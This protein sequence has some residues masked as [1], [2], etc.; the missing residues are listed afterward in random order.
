LAE[1]NPLDH[2]L[3]YAEPRRLTPFSAWHEHIPFAMLLVDLARP[4][5]LVEL[6]THAGDS[7]CAFCQAVSELKL[8][9]KCFAVDTWAGDEHSAAY[10][11]EILADL[12]KHHDPLYGRFSELVQSTFDEAL[13]RFD[14][15]SV[16]VLHI[17]GFHTYEAVRHDFE[18]WL[19]KMSSRGIVLFHDTAVTGFGFGVK[20][21]WDEVRL[22]YAG[23]E[24]LHGN[25]LGVLGVGENLPDAVRGLFDSNE[26]EVEKLR[27]LFAALGRRLSLQI[28]VERL[29]GK[30]AEIKRSIG[31][32]A[33]RR[34]ERFKIRLLPEEEKY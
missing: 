33:L 14:D 17:D 12:R 28:E 18:S 10:G 6:G 25:G 8:D 24:F 16:D 23:F 19:P 13:P 1:I 30:L 11:P 26:E 21:F 15:R 34:L 2:P 32:R 20:T 31:W 22:R 3:V 9:S 4:G 7:Y 29:Q 5:T 27:G